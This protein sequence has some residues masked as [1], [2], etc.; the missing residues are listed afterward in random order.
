MEKLKDTAIKAIKRLPD[1]ATVDEILYE[2][3]FVAQVQKGL[4]DAEEGRTIS[5]EAATK[6]LRRWL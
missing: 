4:K 6:R 2:V 5:H 3:Y 1:D